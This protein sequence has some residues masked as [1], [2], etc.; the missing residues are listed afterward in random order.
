ME[1]KNQIPTFVKKT[2]QILSVHY[3]FI[4]EFFI[5]TNYFMDFK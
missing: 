3:L 1:N 5:L 2:F 4:L